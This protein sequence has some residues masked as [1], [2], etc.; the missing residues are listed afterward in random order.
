MRLAASIGLL[1]MA[2]IAPVLPDPA[3]RDRGVAAVEVTRPVGEPTRET[4][5]TVILTVDGVR[6]GSWAAVDVV[7]GVR[8]FEVRANRI[9]LNRS[10][11]PWAG[12]HL[13]AEL[14]AGHRY[15]LRA[16]RTSEDLVL[17]ELVDET[18]WKAVGS[19]TVP[20]EY[21]RA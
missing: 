18:T 2:C 19:C 7:T 14:E 6:A 5:T 21:G 10:E 17:I 11:A 8:E 13:R 16:S 9:D 1:L 3:M 20:W 12:G 4:W 15:Q